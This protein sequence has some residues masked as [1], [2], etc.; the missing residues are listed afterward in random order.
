MQKLAKSRKSTK[1]RDKKR[2]FL[3]EE[4]RSNSWLWRKIKW[5]NHRMWSFFLKQNVK[6][7][8]SINF[9]FT[10]CWGEWFLNT[11]AHHPII[12]LCSQFWGKSTSAI[13]DECEFQWNGS[14]TS[15]FTYHRKRKASTSTVAVET[16][17]N[18]QRRSWLASLEDK[19]GLASAQ[20][21]SGDTPG[22]QQ[23]R[24]RRRQQRRCKDDRLAASER[25]RC[26]SINS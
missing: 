10:E 4:K 15:V 8:N 5:W 14:M 2:S 21:R 16:P 6:R 19:A 13:F 1:N 17:I 24:Q 22:S 12:K 23:Q 7:P 3:A 11:L 18:H 9:T 26:T 20:I 25:S